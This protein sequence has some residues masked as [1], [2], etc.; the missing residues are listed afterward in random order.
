MAHDVS[1]SSEDLVQIRGLSAILEEGSEPSYLDLRLRSNEREYRAVILL[2]GEEWTLNVR[3]EAGRSCP[4]S[5]EMY[6]TQSGAV[7][8]AMLTA[9]ELSR[10]E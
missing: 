6:V 4:G 5:G 7:L 1:S 10:E 2:A 3:D 8:A 9:L